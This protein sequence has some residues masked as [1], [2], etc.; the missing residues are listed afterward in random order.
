MRI[1]LRL[2]VPV[3]RRWHVELAETIATLGGAVTIHRHA[4]AGATGEDRRQDGYAALLSTERRLH[5]LRPALAA[6]CPPQALARWERRGDG[7]PD[8][9]LDL[10]GDSGSPGAWALTF[11]GAAGTTGAIRALTHGGFPLVQLVRDGAAITLGR[12]GSETPRP[13]AAALEDVL[14]GTVLLLQQALGRPSLSPEEPHLPV[15]QPHRQPPG[16]AALARTVA[17]AGVRRA[18]RAAYRAPHWRVGWRLLD[19]G[20]PDVVDL[21]DHPSGGWATLP[22]DGWHFYADPF[23]VQTGDHHV[24][25]VEDF[26]HRLGRG[27]ISAVEFDDDGPVDVPRPVLEHDVHLSYPYV[28]QDEGEWW[29]V[30]ETSAAGT[31]ELYRA[32]AFPDK[33]AL[34]RVLLKG[35]EASDASVFRHDGRWWLTATVR[36][37]GSWS[38]ALHLWWADHL[39]GPWHPHPR[40]PVLVDI[41]AARPAGRPA[42]R[43]GRLLRPVQDGTAGY[44]A[45]LAVAEVVRLD[46]ESFEQRILAR[47]GPG[48]R[49][50]GTRLHTLNRAGRLETIDGSARSPRFRRR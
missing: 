35:V 48:P 47:L 44:G 38:D 16:T 40:N 20:E 9:V 32:V 25:F 22:D 50:P 13:V 31:V 46:E 23:P 7:L 29:M 21:L 15:E 4:P 2:A 26:D 43:D 27:V 34:E 42:H 5:R 49:W 17:S 30:P 37:G 39:T 19:H 36:H 6:P 12:P 45:G 24:L 18:Y 41:S 3:P 28:L 33:W 14:A 8:L 1:E 10:E 11:D